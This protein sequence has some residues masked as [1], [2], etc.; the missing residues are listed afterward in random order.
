MEATVV[1]KEVTDFAKDDVRDR[2]DRYVRIHTTSDP[3]SDAKPSSA[4]Q[5]DLLEL[6]E[7]ELKPL[8]LVDIELNSRGFVYATLPSNLGRPGMPFGL[9]AHVDSS[10]DQDG[11]NVVPVF[12]ENYDGSPIRFP[13]D[14]SLT[15]TTEDSAELKDFIGKTIITASGNTLLAADDKAGVAEIMAA[16]AAFQRFSFLP[17]GEIRLCFTTDEEVGRGVEGIDTSKLPRF[18]YTMDGG[19]PGELEAECFDARGVTIDI[20]GK[21]VHPGYAYGKMINAAYI[22][23]K[24]VMAL[25]PNERP[26]TTKDRQGFYHPV[27]VS[28]GSEKAQVRLILRDFEASNNDTRAQHL[29]ELARTFESEH[30]GLQINVDSKTQYK[31]MRDILKAYPALIDV[32]ANAIEDAGVPAIRKAIRGG[33]DGSRLSEMGFPTPNIFAGGM[34]FHSRKEYVALESMAQAVAAIIHLAR[35]WENE[36]PRRQAGD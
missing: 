33:T 1:T 4:I 19:Y 7:S 22:A 15:L 29:L 30:P 9:M 34:L 20:V 28:G 31:N 35:R 13:D 21:G 10:P 26:E 12:H 8:G 32:A 24:F 36:G 23:S 25:P 3:H 2:F 14:A 5:M 18:N 27:E 6:L 16:M 17:H 11:K